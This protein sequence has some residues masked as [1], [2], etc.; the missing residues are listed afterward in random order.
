M[1]TSLFQDIS[2]QIQ[3][4][5]TA[6][7][8][9]P[10]GSGKST[11]VSLLEH[12]YEC[13]GG[14][15]FMDGTTIKDYSHEYYHEQVALVSQEP[16]LYSGTIRYNILYGCEEGKVS[17]DEMIE[18]AKLANCHDFIMESKDGYDTMC[19]EKGA[20][21]S[22]KQLNGEFGPVVTIKTYDY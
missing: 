2:I 17:D 15:V 10:S 6:A 8:V 22:G 18:A 7:I 19:G 12:F 9:G 1:K 16:I 21:L 14:N 5:Q 3:P 4:G 11:I 20:A 13:D